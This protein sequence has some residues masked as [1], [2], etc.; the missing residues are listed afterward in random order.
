MTPPRFDSLIFDMDGTLWDAVDSYAEI[1]NRTNAVFGIDATVS[2]RELLDH[3]GQTID[4]IFHS[5]MRGRDVD[6]ERYLRHL[7]H[8]E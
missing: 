5:L 2:R 6:I 1:W 7:D 4:V 3:M 8:C